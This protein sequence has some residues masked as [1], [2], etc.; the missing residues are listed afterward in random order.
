[1]IESL[2]LKPYIAAEWRGSDFSTWTKPD[3]AALWNVNDFSSLDKGKSTLWHHN[4]G[5]GVFPNQT[6]DPDMNGSRLSDAIDSPGVNL[7]PFPDAEDWNFCVRVW[8]RPEHVFPSLGGSDQSAPE[9]EV[10]AL[11]GGTPFS[12]GKLD[13]PVLL[14]GE[15]DGSKELSRVKGQ[16][17]NPNVGAD[18]LWWYEQL[19]KPNIEVQGGVLGNAGVSFRLNL[20]C[21]ARDASGYGTGIERVAVE[22]QRGSIES[23]TPEF[24]NALYRSYVNS[25]RWVKG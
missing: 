11:V 13:S 17:G 9:L 12:I 1:M 5:T 14:P 3:P 25:R 21:A 24:P 4:P 8:W 19:L 6:V 20:S 10:F 23:Q 2:L 7:Q 16:P 18:G 22:I 15:A